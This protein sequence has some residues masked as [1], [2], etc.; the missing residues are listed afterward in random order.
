MAHH[1]GE[2]LSPVAESA[3]GCVTHVFSLL[4]SPV[5]SERHDRVSV[6]ATEFRKSALSRNRSTSFAAPRFLG[7]NQPKSDA[8]RALQKF[9]PQQCANFVTNAG[10]RQQ[11]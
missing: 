9:S 7:S 3:Q 11:L 8:Q 6:A 5:A 1:C 4:M 10:Y 2:S